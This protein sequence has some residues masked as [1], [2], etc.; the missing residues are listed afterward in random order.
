MLTKAEAVKAEAEAKKSMEV[1]AVNSMIQ[2]MDS[3]RSFSRGWK[4]KPP[5]KEIFLV[6]TYEDDLVS[7]ESR[8]PR[9]E[10][11]EFISANS[12]RKFENES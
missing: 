7:A 2:I 10:S 12:F 11:H 1:T 8:E 6:Y 4:D 5:G 3:W 9:A